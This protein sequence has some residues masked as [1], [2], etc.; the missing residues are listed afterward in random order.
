MTPG[1]Y[2]LY[3]DESGDSG[4]SQKSLTRDPYLTL[5]GVAFEAEYYRS[6]FQPA[7]EHFKRRHL[8]YDP[9]EPP[10]LHKYDITCRRG[11]FR[12][13][14][15]A[16]KR[17]N[18]DQDLLNLVGAANFG[19]IAAV[20]NKQAN[21]RRYG[22]RSPEQ[23][24][25]AL[26]GMI[27]RYVGY[28]HYLVGNSVGDVMAEARYKSADRRLSAAYRDIY[29]NGTVNYPGPNPLPGK[30]I[31]GNLTTRSLKLKRKRD[32]IAGLQLAD[33]LTYCCK[34]DVLREYGEPHVATLGAFSEEMLAAVQ[35][36]YN[37]NAFRGTV[38][39]YGKILIQPT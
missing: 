25:Y 26:A 37:H 20:V 8:P 22:T 11:A 39:G 12:C 21:V 28:L 17:A 23:Y 19:L 16:G 4:T 13:L 35:S 38:R 14:K 29:Y 33:L 30:T 3:L 32:N 31:Q 34:I 2:R 18:F 15:D 6:T 27:P 36:K 7:L 1:P 9:D 10:I 5:V 24:C